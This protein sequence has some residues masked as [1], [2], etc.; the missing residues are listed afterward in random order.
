MTIYI[1][2]DEDMED[3]EDRHLKKLQ[4]ETIKKLD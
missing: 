1:E 4:E 3:D 2:K